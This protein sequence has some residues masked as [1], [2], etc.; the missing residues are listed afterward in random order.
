MYLLGYYLIIMQFVFVLYKYLLK[1]LFAFFS[2]K[3]MQK[4]FLEKINKSLAIAIVQVAYA[5][6]FLL[7][8]QHLY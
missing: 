4:T 2:K 5:F 7:R 8:E 1:C 3:K 6:G